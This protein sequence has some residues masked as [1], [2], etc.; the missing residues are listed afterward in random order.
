MLD[1]NDILQDY[2][3]IDDAIEDFVEVTSLNGDTHVYV[4]V[5][6]ADNDFVQILTLTGVDTTLLDML[7]SG[8][9]VV[10]L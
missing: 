4:N 8:N 3:S 5:D 10:E 7:N 9:L 6:G 1:I 2:S